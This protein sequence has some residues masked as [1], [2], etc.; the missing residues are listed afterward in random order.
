MH[1]MPAAL[2]PP[3]T[4]HNTRWKFVTQNTKALARSMSHRRD[5]TRGE[6][7]IDGA[8]PGTTSGQPAAAP[9]TNAGGAPCDLPR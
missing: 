7:A 5:R 8:R 2:A 3:V 4:W 9:E 6:P 1:D